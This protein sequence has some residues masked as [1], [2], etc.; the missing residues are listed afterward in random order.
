MAG[1]GQRETSL[2]GSRGVGCASD[3]RPFDGAKQSRTI[4]SSQGRTVFRHT[5][6]ASKVVLPASLEP[7]SSTVTSSTTRAASLSTGGAKAVSR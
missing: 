4:F 1:W 5:K 6:S 3:S 7:S 2:T